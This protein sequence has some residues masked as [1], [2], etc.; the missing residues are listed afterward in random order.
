[1]VSPVQA[2]HALRPSRRLLRWAL[3]LWLIV[4]AVLVAGL[5][6]MRRGVRGEFR[7]H[8]IERSAAVLRPLVQN[9]VDVA[10]GAHPEVP[11][12]RRLVEALVANA[13]QEGL[14]ALAVFDAD[15]LAL[16]SLP[17][18]RV[19][20]EL[21]MEDYLQLTSGRPICRYHPGFDLASL[22]PPDAGPGR[23]SPVLEVVLPLR[24][25]G[26][27]SGLVGFVRY[28][29]DARQLAAELATIDRRLAVETAV[30]I[31]LG[32]LV[33]TAVFA[34]AYL[35]LARVSRALARTKVDLTLSAKASAL[36]QITS[37]LMHGLQGAVAGLEAAVGDGAAPPDWQAAQAYTKRV[38]AM[39]RETVEMLNDRRTALAYDLTGDELAAIILE[40]TR[41]DAEDRGVSIAVDSRFSGRLDNV[42]GSLVCLV[43]SNLVQ[44]AVAVSESGQVVR[45]RLEQEHQPVPSLCVEVSD[46][47]P[48]VPEALRAHLFEPGFSGK[49]GGS[50][51]GLA[52]SH[53]LAVQL[54]GELVLAVTGPAGSCFRLRIPL[55]V[56]VVVKAG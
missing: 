33:L 36:G 11:Q 14:L 54:D 49:G 40:R 5:V 8:L 6:Q 47:G 9:Q 13:R 17:E 19:F 41:S 30:T 20:V 52:I 29:F 12:S 35:V 55:P 48:G 16:E 32:V 3:A 31:G 28:H 25:A 4:S 21:P 1:M 15:G 42:R 46:A 51:L 50:G 34:M 18:A 23:T 27:V 53:L 10:L 56:E 2:E 45:V 39:V 38:Q 44:N 22:S 26:A 37:H 43:A 24:Q 7:A